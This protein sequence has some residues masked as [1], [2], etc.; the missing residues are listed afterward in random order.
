MTASLANLVAE[1]EYRLSGRHEVDR[2]PSDVAAAIPEA[3]TYVLAL[4]DGL[5][6]AQLEH[7]RA[8]GMQDALVESIEAPFPSTTT[9]SMATIATGMH[10]A[11]HGTIGHQMWVPALD[12]V[13]NVLKWRAPTG[14]T[15]DVD[16]T[17]WLP[18]PNLWERL[19][20]RG[21][22]AITVQPGHF[23]SSPLTRALY[24]GAR[25]EP[26]YADEERIDA[27]IQLASRPGRLI[28][29]Y[30]AEVDFAAHVF[31]QQSPMY[32]DALSGADRAWSALANR[33]PSG[34][35]LI[36]TSDHGHVDFPESSKILVRDARYAGLTFYGDPRALYVKGDRAVIDDLARETGA[37]LVEPSELRSMLGDGADHAELSERLPDCLLLAPP[38]RLLLPRGMDRRLIGYHGGNTAAER[39]I[40]LLVAG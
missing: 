28:F 20:S 31:G 24:R 29:V 6:T 14:D 3:D 4:F 35:A 12:R 40:P 11:T 2:L 10:P 18:R 26:V 23:A 22:E 13:V 5:G 32:D 39:S 33:L 9:V 1:L 34:A 30:F 27:T 21:V 8:A 19:A 36:G 17:D 25:F 37:T 15:I 38:D 16:T 7:A